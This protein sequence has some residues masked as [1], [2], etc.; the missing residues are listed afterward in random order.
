MVFSAAFA[1]FVNIYTIWLFRYF[2]LFLAICFIDWPNFLVFSSSQGS[3]VFVGYYHHHHHHQYSP[4][5][6]LVASSLCDGIFQYFWLSALKWLA[7]FILI[8]LFFC[9]Q[10][11]K[12]SYVAALFIILLSFLLEILCVKPLYS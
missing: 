4:S 2:S 3:F 9:F 1:S 11:M 12:L 7:K 10:I 8:S 6:Q 5:W